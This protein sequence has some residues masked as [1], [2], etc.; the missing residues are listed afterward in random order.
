MLVKI[1]D[2]KVTFFIP[3]L[4][5]SFLSAVFWDLTSSCISCYTVSVYIRI[6]LAVTL[7]TTPKMC[8][9]TLKLHQQNEAA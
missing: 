3:V 2:T 5:F 7:K 8:V 1:I 6:T 4:G 9:E